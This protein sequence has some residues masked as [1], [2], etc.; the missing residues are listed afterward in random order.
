M[1]LKLKFYMCTTWPLDVLSSLLIVLISYFFVLL[2][3]LSSSIFHVLVHMY[4]NLKWRHWSIKRF[5]HGM[6]VSVTIHIT[7]CVS[8]VS[9]SLWFLAVLPGRCDLSLANYPQSHYTS[10]SQ[11]GRR[12]FLYHMYREGSHR[13]GAWSHWHSGM[14]SLQ[15]HVSSYIHCLRK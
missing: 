14:K 8:Q 10:L 7:F 2:W 1:F 3:T 6:H 12:S 15:S 11:H 4:V 13:Q 9:F 5:Y